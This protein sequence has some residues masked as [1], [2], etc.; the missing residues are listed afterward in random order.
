M[1]LETF[2][3]IVGALNG[4]GLRYLIAGGLAVNAHACLRFTR[5]V[6]LDRSLQGEVLPGLLARFVSISTLINR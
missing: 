4:A 5:E 1:R 3:A 2:E 6:E